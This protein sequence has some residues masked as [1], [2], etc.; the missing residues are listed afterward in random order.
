M[1][2]NTTKTISDRCITIPVITGT[3]RRGRVTTSNAGTYLQIDGGNHWDDDGYLHVDLKALPG[4]CEKEYQPSMV[5]MQEAICKIN[6]LYFA[7]KLKV[8]NDLFRI[9]FRIIITGVLSP[10]EIIREMI[11][12]WGDVADLFEDTGK[13]WW[14]YRLVIKNFRILRRERIEVVKR[15]D[16][17]PLGG[18]WQKFYLD[19]SWLKEAEALKG[20]KIYMA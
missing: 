6:T 7:E 5:E 14:K 17:P 8:D 18:T 12:Y 10:I 15:M 4:C 13:K 2:E 3:G 1:L 19:N 11:V 20:N 9:S 16:C